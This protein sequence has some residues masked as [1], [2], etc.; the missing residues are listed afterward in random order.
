MNANKFK[1]SKFLLLFTVVEKDETNIK[2]DDVGN[3]DAKVIGHIDNEVR[4]GIMTSCY[5]S[6]RK[7]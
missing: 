1:K 5:K 3:E 7:N 4:K 6:I 2:K